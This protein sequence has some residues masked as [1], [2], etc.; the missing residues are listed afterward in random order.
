L[1]DAQIVRNRWFTALIAV[2]ALA[3]AVV[4]AFVVAGIVDSIVV[5]VC[6]IGL[7]A[8]FCVVVWTVF[9]RL[10]PARTGAR[11]VTD[12]ATEQR[13]LSTV[14]SMAPRFGMASPRVLVMD[15]PAPNAFAV[16]SGVRATVVCSTSLLELLDEDEL[17]AVCAHELS[18]IANHD[19][20]VAVFGAS[21][22]LWARLMLGLALAAAWF[23]A[24]IGRGFMH[25]TREDA[26]DAV[27][28]ILRFAFFVTAAVV[29][30]LGQIWFFVAK[31]ADL[32]MC[33]QREWM[34]DATAVGV[35]GKPHALASALEKLDQADTGLVHGAHLVQNLCL[36]GESRRGHWWSDL[37]QTH[38][39]TVRRVQRLH[40]FAFPG[41]PSSVDLALPV[42]GETQADALSATSAPHAVADNVP[43]TVSPAP[44][45]A[46]HGVP[47]RGRVM[48]GLAAVAL[49]LAI[50]AA[51]ASWLLGRS[52]R[53]AARHP[54][55]AGTESTQR[56]DAPN[57]PPASVDR[58]SSSDI[59]ASG[60]PA[61]PRASMA[62]ASTV[63]VASAGEPA[64]PN[65][66][67][68]RAPPR[69]STQIAQP[70]DEPPRIVRTET[71]RQG[72]LV[73]FRLFYT[74]SDGDAEGFGFRGV[75]GSGWAEEAH[76]FSSPSFGHVY[77]GILEYPFNHGCG[78]ASEVESSVE[79]WIYD[80]TARRSASVVV[81][82]SC[83]AP[84]GS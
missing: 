27:G 52:D 61:A 51:V 44:V 80:S 77:P 54:D 78:T 20:K 72:V 48:L 18:H 30:V 70:A 31:L 69:A 24:A 6:L 82:L 12:A 39:D 67:E 47:R 55:G 57:A 22:L 58:S 71:Y 41:D 63:V 84:P 3:S 68:R 21:L 4:A 28:G 15:Q 59:A 65:S 40:G 10:A 42:A 74:D 56:P 64:L 45:R 62:P 25:S 66:T 50:S 32:G 83:A 60:P 16:G 5:G 35:T 38:P 29:F 7:I 33:R 11:P 1:I 23:I 26:D 37:F 19:A 13:L 81:R 75:N 43:R 79:A 17:E 46:A 34:A 49:I 14:A 76:P 53:D 36:V 8:V 2:A 9:E 73:Y